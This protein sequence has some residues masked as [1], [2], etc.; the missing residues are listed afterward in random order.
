MAPQGSDDMDIFVALLKL[1]KDGRRLGFATS[2]SSTADRW[3]WAGC[4]HRTTTWIRRSRPNIGPV[5]KHD[6]TQAE[7]GQT[8]PLEI[9][10]WPSDE[11]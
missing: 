4:G 5:L 11:V 10:I 6:G 2:C 9:E 8:V 3:R 1:G 7:D